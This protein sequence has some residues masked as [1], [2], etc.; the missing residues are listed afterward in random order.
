M[1]KH[2]KKLIN[3]Q[4]I[5][6]GGIRKDHSVIVEGTKIAEITDRRIDIPEAEIID[7]QGNYI[8]PGCID[9]HLHGGGGHDFLEA[10][11]D[12]FRS[13]AQ[14][15]AKHGMTAIYA[16]LAAAPRETF[17]RAI[18]AC[19]DVMALPPTGARIMGLHLE[20]NYLNPVMAGGQDPACLYNPDPSEYISLLSSTSCIKRW[21]ASPE[22]EG[23]LDFARYARK[24]GVLV[25]LA[26]TIADYPLVKA[27][28]EAG[29]T[30]TTHFYNAMAGVHKQGVFKKEGT[31]ESIYLMDDMTVE[32]VCDGIHVPPSIMKLVHKV[33]GSERIALVTDAMF[34]AAYAGEVSDISD[35]V[36]VEDGVCKLSDRSALSSSIA[37][38]DRMIRV[39]VGQVGVSLSDAF[40][41]ASETPAKI[42]GIDDRKGTLAKGMDADM[43]VLDSEITIWATMV[44][45]DIVYNRI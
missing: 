40:R 6:P 4:V 17:E 37:T 10:T 11:P 23:A 43:I 44:G 21:S 27:A 42:M 45:G 1:E 29:Y 9:F 18:R 13:I 36:I 41:M 31:I 3:G 12:A 15:H 19:E 2:I 20:G 16:T 34:A 8:A 7:A 33:K 24:H 38:A 28:F 30:H 32:L 35:K 39:M 5:T 26:H 14:A 25:S 22:L